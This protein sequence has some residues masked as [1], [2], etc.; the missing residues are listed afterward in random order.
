ML[1]PNY[2]YA[3]SD[4]S[5]TDGSASVNIVERGGNAAVRAPLKAQDNS[6][7]QPTIRDAGIRHGLRMPGHTGLTI[8]ETLLH[9][10]MTCR[11]YAT[12]HRAHLL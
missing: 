10:S 1:E 4:S 12:G 3:C 8:K 7:P 9:A 11:G 5:Q 2:G 6:R